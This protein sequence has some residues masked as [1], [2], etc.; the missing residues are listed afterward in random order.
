MVILAVAAAF[1]ATL[2][3]DIDTEEIPVGGAVD[4][5]ITIEGARPTAVPKLP[6]DD[7]V[8]VR[9][10]SQVKG[11][12]FLNG[13]GGGYTTLVYQ[14]QG[15]TPGEHKVGPFL[16][17]IG[18]EKLR[19]NALTVKVKKPA[20]A[21]ATPDVPGAAAATAAFTSGEA[22]AGQVVMYGYTIES[23]DEPYRVQWS[24]PDFDGLV[25]PRDAKPEREKYAV[26]L[27]EGARFV[28]RT[29]LPFLATKPGHLDLRGALVVVETLTGDR[30]PMFPGMF[31]PFARTRQSTLATAPSTLDVKA[32][33][34]APPG[35]SGLVGDFDVSASLEAVDVGVGAS[36]GWTLALRGDGTLEGYALPPAPDL[37]GARL[38]DDSPQVRTQVLKGKFHT[39][40]RF[41]R[42][43]VP[44]EV[45]TLQ[46]PPV[47]VVWFSP[48]LG[49]YVTKKLDV[50]LI[51]VGPGAEG[52]LE[53]A[54]FGSDAPIAAPPPPDA[55]R[56]LARTGGAHRWE[57]D[58]L[59]PIT[60][61][62][63]ILPALG[64]LGSALLAWW[65]ARPKKER[66]PVEATPAERLARLPAEPGER[67]AALEAAFRLAMARRAGVAPGALD[68][69][70][71]IAALPDDRR[72]A[73][74]A[75]SRA[76]DRARYAA[77][78]APA[79]LDA[80]VRAAVAAVEA[81]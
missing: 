2:A 21:G 39:E 63:A 32:L 36:I 7:G 48:T 75:A 42:Q 62:L 80:L 66:A 29:W 9:Y 73:A 52:Q 64:A 41:R 1:A 8:E 40:G 59:V 77:E 69:D 49:E 19:A 60:G 31:D 3:V 55:V 37:R 22:W 74:V 53:I 5:R 65:R 27:P 23:P 68:R 18:A 15:L 79:D 56:G 57:L 70:A 47:E 6:H 67:L 46:L 72:A 81:R 11:V 44:T 10:Q 34:P 51:T 54:S 14:V 25:A 38:Y 78:A 13:Q 33:P 45:G 12:T 76:L 17:E 35:F 20:P 24:L 50:P 43:V 16:I 61:G 71:V 28:D 4:L 30:R 58:G 26:T